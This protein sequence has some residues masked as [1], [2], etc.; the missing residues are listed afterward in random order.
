MEDDED[1]EYIWQDREIRFD[2]T[3]KYNLFLFLFNYIE[4]YNPDK[5]K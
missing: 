1:V 4:I 2:S 3:I 5:G